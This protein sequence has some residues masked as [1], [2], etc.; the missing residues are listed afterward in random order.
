MEQQNRGSVDPRI[1][2]PDLFCIGLNGLDR[3][4]S[5]TGAE[6]SPARSFI[7]TDNFRLKL[8]FGE[9][10]FLFRLGSH[11]GSKSIS[12]FSEMFY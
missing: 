6:I 5:E 8:F 7:A 3:C 12:L 11:F 2:G 1:I 9:R 4:P 10:K